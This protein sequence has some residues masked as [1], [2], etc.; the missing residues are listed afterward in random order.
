[1]RSSGCICVANLMAFTCG[2]TRQDVMAAAAAWAR[3]VSRQAAY[4]LPFAARTERD[5]LRQ[6]RAA[7]ARL[8]AATATGVASVLCDA[9]WLEPRGK[10]PSTTLKTQSPLS[11]IAGVPVHGPV[12]KA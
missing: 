10:V 3:E 8:R 4:R 12:A 9:M 7:E 2:V 11:E 5:A 1:V 6:W